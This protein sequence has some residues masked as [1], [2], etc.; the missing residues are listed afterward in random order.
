M[1]RLLLKLLPALLCLSLVLSACGQ[2]AAPSQSE[3]QISAPETP[4][5]GL[6]F[7]AAAQEVV[8]TD[9]DVTFTDSLGQTVTIAKRPERVVSLLNSYTALWYQAGGVVVG[10][11]ESE[12]E[13]PPEALDPAIKTVGKNASSVSTELLLELQPDLVLLRASWGDALLGQLEQND[14]P[15]IALEYN[16]FADYLKWLKVFT[17]LNGTEEL[18]QTL[19]VDLLT[20]I[21][22]AIAQVPTEES[23]SVMLMFGTTSSVK[24]YLS[25]TAVGEMLAQ[26][27]AVNIADRWEDTTA[28]SVEMNTEYLITT[29]PDFIL[30][31][32]MGEIDKVRAYIESQYADEDW[33]KTLSAVQNDRVIYLDRS[34][35]HYK[36][37][38]RYA[39]AY[40]E[41]A[42]IL[43][44]ATFS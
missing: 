29:D 14:I 6:D 2:S 36:P 12:T 25:N 1:K 9:T 27:G 35:F 22:Q 21:D 39:E 7:E 16:G 40:M 26:L 19:G 44:P 33:W 10:R 18:Y 42:K 31:Q 24:A 8:V 20:Q 37:N 17:A 15:Y 13:L 41:L 23:P 43:Y 11:L 5:S 30:V 4:A 3:P 28:T 32:C 38:A 34:L